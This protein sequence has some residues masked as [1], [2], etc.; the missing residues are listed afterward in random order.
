MKIKDEMIET[1][2][3][4]LCAQRRLHMALQINLYVEIQNWRGLGKFREFYL[5]NQI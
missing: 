3:P 2:H 4:Y 5:S 1:L